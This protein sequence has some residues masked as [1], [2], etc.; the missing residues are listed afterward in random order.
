MRF[1]KD[2]LQTIFTY[3]YNYE[4]VYSEKEVSRFQIFGR[5]GK[6]FLTKDHE[7][8]KPETLYQVSESDTDSFSLRTFRN[9]A[10]VIE[11]FEISEETTKT[12]NIRTFAR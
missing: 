9:N 8:E 11:N 5:K 12:K 10:G 1:S 2:S 6:V 7:A 4:P 3:F